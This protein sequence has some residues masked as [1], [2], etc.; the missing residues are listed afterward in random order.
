[1]MRPRAMLAWIAY[2]VPATA[3]AL[4][5]VGRWLVAFAD[6]TAVLYGEGA[7]ANAAGL[8]RAGV[9]YLDVDPQRFVA[10]N[11][12]PVYF[13]L[14]SICCLPRRSSPGSHGR[15]GQ[16]SAVSASA[17]RWRSWPLR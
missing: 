3:L 10:A 17:P 14:A 12:P 4:Y 15:I 9:A 2:L 11:Y 13:H 6:R 5:A 1:M 8:A 7:V 16:R